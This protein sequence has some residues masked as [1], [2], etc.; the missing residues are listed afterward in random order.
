MDSTLIRIK[1][2]ILAG[3][4]RFSIKAREEMDH[5][6][7]DVQDVIESIVSA[8]SIQKTIRSTS[9]FRTARREML[10]IIISPTF[11]GLLLYTK[12]K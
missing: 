7:L 10:Y 8:P 1:K 2:A 11:S 3:R 12:G 6:G 4:Y 9:N 5:D